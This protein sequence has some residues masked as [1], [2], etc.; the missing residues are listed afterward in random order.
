MDYSQQLSLAARC[1]ADVTVDGVLLRRAEPSSELAEQKQSLGELLPLNPQDAQAVSIPLDQLSQPLVPAVPSPEGAAALQESA[2]RA[3]LLATAAQVRV[4]ADALS[5]LDGLDAA[6]A[7]TLIVSGHQGLPDFPG[8]D[9][10]GEP[11]Q[12]QQKAGG[13]PEIGDV[14]GQALAA[15]LAA[16]TLVTLLQLA[17]TATEYELT[18]LQAQQL[19]KQLDAWAK[20]READ[21]ASLKQVWALLDPWR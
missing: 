19:D 5:S 3:A 15:H 11:T 1:A 2:K 20:K 14:F 13:E 12:D 9:F 7:L 16:N 8:P 10:V 18:P 4:T 6:D 17:Q 21:D